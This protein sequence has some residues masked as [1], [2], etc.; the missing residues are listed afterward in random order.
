MKFQISDAI[1]ALYPDSSYS[2]SNE[3]YSTLNWKSESLKPTL[4]ELE[5]KRDQMQADYD[6]KQYQRDRAV[7]Y[8]PI[9]DQ[10]DQ[11][12]WDMDGWKARIK[13]VKDKHPKP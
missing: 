7:A 4:Q 2:I 6:A 9:P 5:T 1:Y 8:D 3:D 12:Y 11:I 10:L 13:S